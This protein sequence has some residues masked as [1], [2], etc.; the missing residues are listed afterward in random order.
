MDTNGIVKGMSAPV[1]V[2]TISRCVGGDLFP[3]E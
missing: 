1:A 2:V 3:D